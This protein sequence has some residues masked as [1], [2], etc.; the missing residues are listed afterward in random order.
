M[1]NIKFT[2]LNL[3]NTIIQILT[4]HKEMVQNYCPRCEIQPWP[5]IHQGP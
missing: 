1:G 5:T 2:E 4:A 3:H